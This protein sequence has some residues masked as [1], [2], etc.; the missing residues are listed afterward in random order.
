MLEEDLIVLMER[1]Q[2]G[3]LAA[4][5]TLYERL[6]PALHRFLASSW[7]GPVDDLVQETFLQLHRARHTYLPP[8][9]VLPWVYAIARNVRRMDR[10]SRGRHRRFEVEEPEQTLAAAAS[11]AT[12]APADQVAV[13]DAL[14]RLPADRREALVL[15]HVW[16]FSFQ[17]IGSLLGVRDGTVKVRA[18]RG[19]TTLR[20]LLAS[21]RGRLG[22]PREPS[23]GEQRTSPENVSAGDPGEPALPLRSPTRSR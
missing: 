22:G 4:F 14:A 3:E 15:H 9:P 16:G 1:Y 7:D 18:H 19:I 10:R 5:E 11:P 23:G 21:V 20:S 12:D 8:R 2:G 17:E 6:A 13:R